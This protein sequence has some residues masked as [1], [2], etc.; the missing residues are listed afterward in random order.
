MEIRKNPEKS[1]TKMDKNGD[2]KNRDG[3]EMN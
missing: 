1:F 3:I 2:L